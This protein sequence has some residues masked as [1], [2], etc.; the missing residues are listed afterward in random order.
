MINDFL[1]KL[2]TKALKIALFIFFFWLIS[3]VIE[4]SFFSD[5]RIFSDFYWLRH[6]TIFLFLILLFIVREKKIGLRNLIPYSAFFLLL[7]KIIPGISFL[8]KYFFLF[9]SFLLF[10]YIKS[11]YN[12]LKFKHLL[13]KNLYIIIFFLLLFILFSPLFLKEGYLFDPLSVFLNWP[14]Y[15]LASISEFKESTGGASDLFDAFL[16]KWRYTYQSIKEGVLPLWQ[17]NK[18]LGA[19]IYH[20]SYHPEELISFLVK[21]SEALTL[22]VLFRLLLSMMGMFFLLR[23]INIG[24]LA[25]IIGGLAYA[26]SGFIIG[27]LHGPQASPAYHIPFLF[28]F[29]IKYL[30]TKKTK[31]LFYFAICAS[32]ILCSG[33]MTVAGY[34]FYG[35]GLFLG[36]FFLFDK[37]IL[38]DKV[39]QLLKISL[40]WILAIITVS[41]HF[42]PLFYSF[43]IS[44]EFDISYRNIGRVGYLSPKYLMN[45]LF[46]FFHGW[47]I[48]PE[49]RPYVSSILFVFF[50]S[51]VIIF[52]IRLIKSE[53]EI[54]DREKYYLS[55][56]LLLVS[57]IM[58]M[59]GLFPF[60]QISCKLP[61]LNSSPLSRLQCMSCFLLVVLGVKGL[62]FFIKSYSK[63]LE[64]Y[65]KRKYVFF[66]VIETLFIISAFVGL[67]SLCSGK[68]TKYHQI[69]P[70]FILLSLVI[71][72]LQISIF[73]KKNSVFFLILLLPLVLTD[74]IIQNHHYITVNKESFF[75]T[76]IETPLI[77]FVKKNSKRHEGVL[78]FDS[79]YNTNGTLGSYGI[80]EKIVHQF[81][82]PDHKQL[83][84]DTFSQQSFASPT[85]P[86]LVSRF[87]DFR[88]PLIQLLG[89][90]FLIFPY[91]FRGVNLP[92][93]YELLYNELDG[94]VYRNNLYLKNKGIFFGRPKYYKTENKN[95]VIKEIK[96]MD[97]SENIYIEENKKID[98]DFKEQ[99]TCFIEITEYTPN[100]VVYRYEAGSD[101][102][103]TFPEA[104]DENWSVE[105][106]GQKSQ[107]L[108][109]NLIFRGVAV[110]EGK[111]EIVFKYHISRLFK[112]LL[113]VGLLSLIFLI[114]L[115][116]FSV[117]S[118]TALR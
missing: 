79:N 47:D 11:N 90:K 40:F 29:L 94:K 51:G 88:S 23:E 24:N 110:E 113:L 17:F 89:V 103:L 5:G 87:T 91:E 37:Q 98:L 27:W 84:V 53:G 117:K 102:I 54:I 97:Y 30:K 63:I 106:N 38:L 57:F 104:F 18:G 93:Y 112:I 76:K 80:R 105:V 12:G 15:R 55:F 64:F 20:Q 95:E 25:S 108:R 43:F 48:S 81:Y 78:V 86:A 1:N 35:V 8:S 100:K 26:F 22:R 41:F 77:N 59:C 101:G 46:P 72:V 75:I 65:K 2:K 85:A 19:A 68:E 73:C 116:S 60:Y 33:F 7:L 62:D 45:I 39:R 70:L 31:F 21:P 32:L 36:F 4:I 99:M 9:L 52:I 69:Y 6:L 71:L 61:V 111:G 34:A 92:P 115:Y 82:H 42:I 74:L 114:I 56:F 14:G 3:L 107:V 44:Q 67:S 58:A 49:I 13:S 83:I 96:Y 109:T 16:P 50:I 118:Q 10:L 66:I 28:F